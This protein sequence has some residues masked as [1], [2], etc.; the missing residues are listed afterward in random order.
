MRWSFSGPIPGM[1][2][3]QVNEPSEPPQHTWRDNFLCVPPQSP[4]DFSFSPAGPIP[5]RHCLRMN[6]PSDPHTWA[7]NFLCWSR[8]F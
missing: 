8:A 1:R 3:T 7:D 2:C 6:E 4:L 5:G